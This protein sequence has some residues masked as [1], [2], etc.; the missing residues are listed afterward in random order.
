MAYV[1]R[2]IRSDNNKVF[3]IGIGSDD[4][5]FYYRAYDK[6]K[7]TRSNHWNSVVNKTKYE[8]EIMLDCLS[9]EEACEKEKE[10]ISLYGRSDLGKGSLVN[11][12][13]GGDGYSNT[14]EETKKLI[15]KKVKE[16]LSNPEVRKKISD[17]GKGRV[18]NE[19]T[20]QKISEKN[21]G[22]KRPDLVSINKK[23]SKENHPYYGKSSPKKYLIHALHSAFVLQGF[24]RIALFCS[25]VSCLF[26]FFLG[27]IIQHPKL[28]LQLT[29]QSWLATVDLH[30]K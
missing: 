15:S 1:Y 4:S 21:K 3:Y 24:N 14:S 5:G 20:K 10:F 22:R 16:A 2:H 28:L 18:V 17:K 11:K 12:T 7:K 9:W 8:V 13:D 29:L 6:N 23:R 26:D 27:A 30:V 19:N 25:I